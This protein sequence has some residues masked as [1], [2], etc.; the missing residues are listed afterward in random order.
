MHSACPGGGVK[1]RPSSRNDINLSRMSAMSAQLSETRK[2]PAVGKCKQHVIINIG[3][4]TVHQE[5][6]KYT[7]YVV[8]MPDVWSSINQLGIV[9][10]RYNMW[11]Y[12]RLTIIVHPQLTELNAWSGAHACN[13][14]MWRGVGCK[15]RRRRLRTVLVGV[16]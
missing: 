15:Y 14:A 13:Y 5:S 7:S 12:N 10:T 2:V 3:G 4:L 9:T 1:P 16:G 11:K 6:E 8:V